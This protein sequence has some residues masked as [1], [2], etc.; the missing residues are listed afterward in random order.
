MRRGRRSQAA[1]FSLFAFHDIITSVSAIM[2]LIVLILT[3]EFVMRNR[4]TG[5][6]ED[7]RAVARELENALQG[8]KDR[9]RE[10]A[11]EVQQAR[12][13]ADAVSGVEASEIARRLEEQ[14]RNNR[15]SEADVDA[16][17]ICSEAA[18]AERLEAESLLAEVVQMD[19][20]RAKLEQKTQ[21]S[22]QLRQAI[23]AECQVRAAQQADPSRGQPAV[24]VAELVFNPPPAGE[25]RPA[26]VELTQAGVAVGTELGAPSTQLGW[27]FVGPP[28]ALKALLRK[29]NPATE[30]VLLIVRPSGIDRFDTVKEAVQEVGLDHGTELVGEKT[31]LLRRSPELQ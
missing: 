15:S 22:E 18:M 28:T 26:S 2:I 27:G 12:K 25:K 13:Q 8:W 16:A 10:L 14:R 21:Q 23:E 24:A 6:A 7:H 5:V 19:R 9:M 11:A 3:L 31:R 1:P 17:E 20:D 29:R 4:S 30:S